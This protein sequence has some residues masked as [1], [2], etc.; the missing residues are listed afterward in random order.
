ML[1]WGTLGSVLD[2]FL[3]GWL[4][5]S[6]IDTRTGRI[7]EGAGGKK[8]L[9]SKDGV[10]SMHFKKRAEV[11]AVLQGGE[12]KDTVEETEA[13]LNS[14]EVEKKL[15]EKMG[16]PQR[17]GSSL[18][19]AKPSRVVESGL[20][21][22]DNNEVNFLMALTMSLGAMGLASWAWGIPLRSAI[23]F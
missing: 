15:N 22:L 10:N 14:A 8:V 16:S 6:V 2:S 11:K 23:P 17:R 12:G 13:T 21:L 20:G 9:V 3:G 4:Q 1:A 5:Q 18:E 19:N 7:I